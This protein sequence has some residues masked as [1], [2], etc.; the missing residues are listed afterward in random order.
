MK[1]LRAFTVIELL[2]VISI[3]TILIAILLP[4]LASARATARTTQCLA[5]IRQLCVINTTYA[6]EHKGFLAMHRSGSN[7]DGIKWWTRMGLDGPNEKETA[8]PVQLPVN[9]ANQIRNYLGYSAFICWPKLVVSETRTPRFEDFVQAPSKVIMFSDCT[10][11]VQYYRMPWNYSVDTYNFV[12]A[13]RHGRNT[14]AKGA[15]ANAVFCDGH[16]SSLPWRGSLITNRNFIW[17]E[18]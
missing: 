4:A 11:E 7:D 17:W 16:A 15:V 1:H 2:V 3:I 6:L 12:M 13:F 14:M 10:A 18:K 9:A 5:K 8:C